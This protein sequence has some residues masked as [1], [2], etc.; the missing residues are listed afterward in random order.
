MPVPLLVWGGL[1][2]AGALGIGGYAAGREVG[3]GVNR[4]IPWLM[5]GTAI[6]LVM[7]DAK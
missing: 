6:Y 4:A 7:K 2:A 5:A 1:A 3:Q